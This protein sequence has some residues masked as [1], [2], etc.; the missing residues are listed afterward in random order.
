MTDSSK[1]EPTSITTR[2]ASGPAMPDLVQPMLATAANEPF[3]SSDHIFE[4]MWGG[5]RAMAHVRDGALRVR[6][7]NG[8]QLAG[9][10]PELSEIPEMLGAREAIIDGEIVVADG[11]GHPSFDALRPRLHAVAE[12]RFGPIGPPPEFLKPRKVSGQV[13][14]Q[15]FDLLWLD[16]RSIVDRPLWQR[17]N[18]LHEILRPGPQ[19]AAVDFVDD[20][21][22]AFF[23]AVVQRR[24]EGVVAKEKASLYAPGRRSRAWRE[25]RALQAA[26]FVIGG[27]TLGASRRK[28]EPF[29]QLLLGAY[30]DSRLEY[31]GAVSGGFSDS[32]GRQ[33]V[34]MLEPLLSDEPPFHDPPV[35]PRLI[36]WTKALLVCRVRFSEWS[37][38]GFLRFPIFCSLRPEMEPEDCVLEA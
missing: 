19:F 33:I 10:F 14:F 12:Q 29:S 17:K 1:D 34:S 13:S 22:I 27:Y 30:E 7:R 5:L 32:E 16:G 28:G 11:E 6:A 25:V 21:G 23:D 31:V 8:C 20:E 9:Q 4:L 24:L 2:L 3:D 18:R 26:D 38:E 36:Y 35:I 15:A 37:R